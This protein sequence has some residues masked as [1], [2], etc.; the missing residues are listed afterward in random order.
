MVSTFPRAGAKEV[1]L[2]STC[3]LHRRSRS[4]KI[5]SDILAYCKNVLNRHQKPTARIVRCFLCA[6]SLSRN[7]HLVV[8]H[9]IVRHLNP[10][11]L[12]CGYCGVTKAYAR[13]MEQHMAFSHDKGLANGWY[14]FETCA[15]DHEKVARLIDQCFGK[16]TEKPQ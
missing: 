6:A 16:M 14:L 8:K 9:V 15:L 11:Q 4:L 3:L 2:T 13:S 7:P 5:Y 10:P 1:L 12:D